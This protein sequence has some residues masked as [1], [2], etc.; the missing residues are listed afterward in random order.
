MDIIDQIKAYI[1]YNEQEKNDQQHILQFVQNNE[2]VFSRTN[3]VAH[4]TASSWIVNRSRTKLLMIYHNIYDSWSWT[5]GHADGERNLLKVAQIEAIEET[6]LSSVTLLYPDIF[7]LEV[8][9]VDGHIKKD[10]YISSHLHFNITYLFEADDQEIL[11][12]K[13]DENSDVKW[14]ELDEAI[15]ASSEVWFKKW[16]YTKL[17]KKLMH[18]QFL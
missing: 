15:Q 12:H 13:P 6:G 7:S 3:A 5:G 8:L 2:D 4:F 11:V 18:S 16:V 1:P 10:E 14:F 17:N 9:T